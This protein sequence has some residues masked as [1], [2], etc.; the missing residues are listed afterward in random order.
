MNEK[1]IRKF[2]MEGLIM[3]LYK[4][5][6]QEYKTQNNTIWEIGKT[7][8]VVK[9][10]N[11]QLCSAYVL[12]AYKDYSLGLA[13]NPNHANINNP[14]ILEVE[15]VICVQDWDKVGSFELKVIREIQPP[16]WYTDKEIRKKVL[17]QFAIY[18]AEEALPIWEAKYPQD[19]R[20]RKAIEAAKRCLAENF[21]IDS[22]DAAIAAAVGIRAAIDAFYE[23]AIAAVVGVRAAFDAVFTVYTAVRAASG[24]VA[25]VGVRVAAAAET[26]YAAV[27]FASAAEINFKKLLNKAIKLWLIGGL[28]MRKNVII[29]QILTLKTSSREI[30]PWNI[31]LKK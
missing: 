2:K 22:C 4:L 27:V 30:F 20:P 23:H 5:V 1:I 8:A 16:K 3:K 29:N 25:I 31:F 21:S 12:H 24:D 19:T 14:R 13:M 18:C 17:V 10:E 15:G 7:N 9:T 28:K 6:D 26:A 11:P